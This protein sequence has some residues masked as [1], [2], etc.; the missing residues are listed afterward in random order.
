VARHGA[1]QLQ[2]VTG[3]DLLFIVEPDK[4]KAL[5]SGDGGVAWGFLLRR[6]W[7]FSQCG[8]RVVIARP[9]ADRSSLG[10]PTATLSGRG[11]SDL[12][13][14]PGRP[15]RRTV[16]IPTQDGRVVALRVDTGEP[17]WNGA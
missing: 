8:Q 2:P 7:P 14:T 15:W 10:R 6:S 16:Y 13:R 9:P 12:Q 3:D 1:A 5:Q 11:T 17:V 4:L